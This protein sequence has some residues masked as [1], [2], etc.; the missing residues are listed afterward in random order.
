ME[1]PLDLRWGRRVR[2][3]GT[4]GLAASIGLTA[5]A[6]IHPGASAF[7][8]GGAAA[9]ALVMLVGVV[10]M[11]VFRVRVDEKLFERRTIRGVDTLAWEEVEAAVLVA[12][13]VR[14]NTIVHTRTL[15]PAA[16]SHVLLYPHKG[17]RRWHFHAWMT[18]FPALVAAARS[19]DLVTLERP[20]AGPLTRGEQVL[21]RVL[22]RGDGF[23]R[24]GA[25]IVGWF[26]LVFVLFVASLSLVDFFAVS[27][28]GPFFVHLTLVALAL[29]GLVYGLTLVLRAVGALRDVDD[30]GAA[31]DG[32]WPMAAASLIGGV[33]L[34]VG[35]LPRALDGDAREWL[36]ALLVVVGIFFVWVPLRGWLRGE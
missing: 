12:T 33:L 22:D 29:L 8:V 20:E 17:G 30:T 27:V 26:A 4:L 15:D 13:H 1:Q 2:V 7:T 35:F 36:D 19:R 5:W 34:V 11:F 6:R 16:A 31:S 10:A 25:G 23:N 14:G 28:F 9:L 21:G 24:L 32:E 3:A 18:E